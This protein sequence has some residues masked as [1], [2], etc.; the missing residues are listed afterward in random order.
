VGMPNGWS[1][2]NGR[3]S[4]CPTASASRRAA[5]G[6]AHYA[7]VERARAQRGET[8]FITGA[9]GGVGL[10]AVDLSR[11]LSLRI[12]A[13]IGSDD[14]LISSAPMVPLRWSTTARKT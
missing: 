7:L 8:V 12:I 10:A 11:N 14:R 6:T 1:P 13:G 9:A 2:S 3:L 5:Y 4:R